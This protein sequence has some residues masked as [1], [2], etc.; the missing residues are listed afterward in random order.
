MRLVKTGAKVAVFLAMVACLWL[1][2]GRLPDTVLDEL[3]TLRTQ[4]DLPS[5]TDI[6]AHYLQVPVPPRPTFQTKLWPEELPGLGWDYA[7]RDRAGRATTQAIVYARGGANGA[8][9]NLDWATDPHVELLMLTGEWNYLQPRMEG[10][11]GQCLSVLRWRPGESVLDVGAGPGAVTFAL[12]RRMRSEGKGT[13]RLY[14]EDVN[15][16]FVRFWRYAME[17]L[18]WPEGQ[19]IVPLLGATDDVRA[20]AASV[21]KVLL[22]H[23]WYWA[24]RNEAREEGRFA[25]RFYLEEDVRRQG[26]PLFASIDR[27][28]RPGGTVHFMTWR[29]AQSPEQIEDQVRRILGHANYR[30]TE[31]KVLEHHDHK[32]T[33]GDHVAVTLQKS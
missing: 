22:A 19:P 6:A 18:E 12:A 27:A 24:V 32:G 13:E 15:P 5:R 2:S 28:L 17:R 11:V 30:V 21:D 1:Q 23:V 20:P 7:W 31:V 33:G 29:W 8:P 26:G 10:L 4:A 14:A 16:G 25:P 9:P 3:D